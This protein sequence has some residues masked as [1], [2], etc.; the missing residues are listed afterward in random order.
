MY[1]GEANIYQKG[2]DK[3]LKIAQRFKIMGLL[4]NFKS[5]DI[6]EYT[7]SQEYTSGP[8]GAGVSDTGGEK[9][10]NSLI[11]VYDETK[12]PIKRADITKISLNVDD[13]DDINQHADKLIETLS[14]GSLKCAY[15]GKL[16]KTGQNM[17]CHTETHLDGL[18]FDCHLCAKTLSSRNSLRLHVSRRHGTKF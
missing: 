8:S 2:L 7:T 1:N 13:I 4:Q 16:A 18:S 9:E 14:D 12:I 6:N 10:E 5:D 15:C 3:F 17:R 11:L